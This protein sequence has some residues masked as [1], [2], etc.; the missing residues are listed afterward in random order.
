MKIQLEDYIFEHAAMEKALIQL[1]VRLKNKR[2]K[3]HSNFLIGPSRV[4]KTKTIE[5][6]AEGLIADGATV[7]KVD[8]FAEEGQSFHMKH[9]FTELAEA[10]GC[11]IVGPRKTT[12][13]IRRTCVQ[14]INENKVDYVIVDEADLFAESATKRVTKKNANVIKS[15]AN[16]CNARFLFVGTGALLDLV[17]DFGQAFLRSST[18]FLEPYYCENALHRS[19]FSQ[20]VRRLNEQMEIPLHNSLLDKP[21]FLHNHSQGC[22]GALAGIL[23][24]SLEMAKSLGENVITK[25]R[26]IEETDSAAVCKDVLKEIEGVRK[27]A[28]RRGAA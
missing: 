25:D 12:H 21:K 20:C 17:I 3:Q 10:G 14:F 16:A 18:T 8:A 22:V 24:D 23:L 28:A 26:I 4:G 7:I 15:L 19:V 2:R 9:F 1:R 13:E 27:H 5:R 6:L 11:P